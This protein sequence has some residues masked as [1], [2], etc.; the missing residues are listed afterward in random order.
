MRTGAQH[1]A[2]FKDMVKTVDLEF[3]QLKREYS[4]S[5][6]EHAGYA[7]KK[8]N[9]CAAFHGDFPQIR[10]GTQKPDKV[11]TA[12]LDQAFVK[13][14]KFFRRHERKDQQLGVTV[15]TETYYPREG[16]NFLLAANQLL[17]SKLSEA[18]G[19]QAD[20]LAIVHGFP[21][22]KGGPSHVVSVSVEDEK[23]YSI[24]L[25]IHSDFK[26]IPEDYFR[27]NLREM[28]DTSDKVD[29]AF[30]GSLK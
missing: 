11:A 7:G 22:E 17:V 26:A 25:T 30:R 8:V 1:K 13:V 28:S 9:A 12:E 4:S 20:L 24:E 2:Y 21:P 16:L 6:L 23:K 19:R 5:N 29:Q 10:F 3:K 14:A 15:T 18:F 27:T